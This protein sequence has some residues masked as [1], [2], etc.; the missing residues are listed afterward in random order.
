MYA[1]D[2]ACAFTLQPFSH[3]ALGARECRG[4]HRNTGDHRAVRTRMSTR[5]THIRSAVV[6]A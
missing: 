4:G 5:S 2:V 6:I 3:T 1:L